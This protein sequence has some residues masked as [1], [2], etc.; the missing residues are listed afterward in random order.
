[1]RALPNL[2]LPLA[3]AHGADMHVK[4]TTLAFTVH[5]LEKNIAL[6]GHS[7]S[8]LYIISLFC[9]VVVVLSIHSSRHLSFHSSCHPSIQVPHPGRMRV[10]KM[11]EEEEDEWQHQQF[12]QM[13]MWSNLVV[14]EKLL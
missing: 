10:K 7:S 6:I 1:V 4:P 8:S 5:R 2:G 9:P 13:F 11:M 3:P 12:I 14:Y